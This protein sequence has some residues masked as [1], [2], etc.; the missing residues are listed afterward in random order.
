MTKTTT[1]I[2]DPASHL[3]TVEDVAAYLEAAL[4]DGDPQLVAAALGDIA[5]ARETL[6][7]RGLSGGSKQQ[8]VPLTVN[9][10]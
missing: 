1:T 10:F 4:Q 8:R 5:R 2:W 9:C 3:S 7:K 6:D